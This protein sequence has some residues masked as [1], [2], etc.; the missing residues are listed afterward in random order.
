MQQHSRSALVLILGS[1]LGASLLAGPAQ[2]ADN[3]FALAQAPAAEGTEVERRLTPEQ[4]EQL[5]ERARIQAGG[6]KCQ[7]GKAAPE[8]QQAPK[9]L[10][11]GK[12]S[13]GFCGAGKCGG[14]KCGES[15]KQ[16][17]PR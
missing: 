1:L 14:G 9:A 17:A 10:E 6:A 5:K 4:G 2:A 3:P 12:A 11:R 8:A 15:V 13:A 16:Q 7:A